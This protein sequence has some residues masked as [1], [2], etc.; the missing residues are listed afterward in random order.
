[1]FDKLAYIG[2]IFVTMGKRQIYFIFI[3][4]IDYTLDKVS[5]C[6]IRNNYQI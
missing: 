6:A 2:E 3:V 4:K 1:M 5:L